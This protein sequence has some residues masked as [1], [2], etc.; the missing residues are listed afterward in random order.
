MSI[1]PA[2]LSDLRARVRLSEIVGRSVTFDR[3]KSNPR[4]GDYWACCPFHGEKTPS[5]HVED[6][7]ARYYCFGCHAKGDAISFLM[8]MQSMSFIEAVTALAEEAGLEVP[9]PTPQAAA[10]E[11]ER[12]GLIDVLEAAARVFEEALAGPS[13]AGARAY[14]ER[15]GLSADIQ[16]RFRLGYAP[17]G[18]QM[19]Q[20]ALTQ[21]GA[22]PDLLAR[23]GLTGQRDPGRA[24][25]DYFRDRLMFPI[26]DGQGRVI[27]FGGRVL[28]AQA[29]PKYLNSPETE[30]FHKGQVLYNLHLARR[31]LR[32]APPLLLA[33]GYMDVIA[34][35]RAGLE[36]AVAPLGTALT[37][38]QLT[39]AWR[40][41][42]E[43]VLCFDGDG[44]G[45]RAAYRALDLA[46]PMIAPDRTLRFALL[47][48]G[49]DPDDLLALGGPEALKS[50]VGKAL[51]VA[52]LLWQRERDALPLDTPE[53]RAGLKAR[54]DGAVGT[55]AD[56]EVR[57]QMGVE[58]RGRAFEHMRS[59][60]A[61]DRAAK[62]GARTGPRG[63]PAAAPGGPTRE[64][65]GSHLAVVSKHA[66][67][68]R[69][70]A[71]KHT[72]AAQTALRSAEALAVAQERD[73][74]ALALHH[75]WLLE[76]VAE[77]L[78]HL[79]FTDAACARAGDALLA[80]LEAMEEKGLD[81]DQLASHLSQ[82]VGAPFV[83]QTLKNERIR[84]LQRGWSGTG[85]DDIDTDI[86]VDIR[87]V[88][89]QTMSSHHRIVT[90]R[91]E[92]TKALVAFEANQNPN[93]E[94]LL[95]ET[96]EAVTSLTRAASATPDAA[97]VDHAGGGFP[98]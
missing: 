58:L 44:A 84:A 79:P 85:P 10:R 8:D 62:G 57:Y 91:R 81:R 86:R 37:Q 14:L 46:L 78:A 63:A 61:G 27:G 31:A 2:F 5:F 75:P 87:K 55:I 35:S 60:R 33:E 83:A 17:G 54:L 65:A 20:A 36:A 69:P 82:R 64:L 96:C 93:L 59:L 89:R 7:K 43:P 50:V 22:T 34:L 3:Q 97:Q 19:L 9:K 26:A 98:S 41:S 18:G 48:P 72:A 70:G 51:G 39:A 47:P 24:P 53:R 40:L 49:Q 38:D 67:T 77:D 25:Y 56:G 15:R 66:G 76:E 73:L 29:Q 88:W 74:L 68:A 94:T 1:S 13:G 4:K 12:L 90:C 16:S 52:D 28:D 71:A 6:E 80:R 95:M 30:V 32:Q 42:S 21:Q 11:R 45:R 92:L 23:A